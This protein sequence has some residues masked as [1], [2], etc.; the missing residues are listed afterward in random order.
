MNTSIQHLP[1]YKQ[2]ELN[3]LTQLLQQ[4]KEIEMVILFGSYARNTW[5]EDRYVEKGTLYEYKSDFDI[6][7]VTTHDDLKRNFKIRKKI[8]EELNKT[9]RTP[10]GLIFHSVKELNQALSWG[11][12]FFCD[13]KK[14]GILLYD[15]KKFTLQNPKKLSPKESQ[16]KAQEYYDQWFTSANEFYVT[17]D[18]AMSKKWY[19]KAAFELHQA[20]ERYYTAIQLVYTD[21]RPK[22]HDLE[23][24]DIRVRNSDKRFDVF[25]RTT[26]E[27]EHLFELLRR[28]YIDARYKMDE[29]SI[30]ESQLNYLSER[31]LALKQ[32]TQEL[33]K[34]RIELIGQEE[35][36]DL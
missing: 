22:E 14:E 16:Q 28:A 25:P 10:L 11:S 13:I 27:E 19:L 24:L 15:S 32:L 12:Y 3:A 36:R 30:T 34:E 18:F 17:F 33:C 26:P 8:K 1:S 21:Y 31:V 2:N 23:R 29:Y 20:T 5:V 9:I 6:L 4:C 7:V 35:P